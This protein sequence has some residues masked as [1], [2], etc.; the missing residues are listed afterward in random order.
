MIT[1]IICS[2]VVGLLIGVIT[3]AMIESNNPFNSC[4][5]HWDYN[6]KSGKV[7]GLEMRIFQLERENERLNSIFNS[8][9][10][11]KRLFHERYAAHCYSC[12]KN[13]Y[14]STPKGQEVADMLKNITLT[15]E[16]IAEKLGI[17]IE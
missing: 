6:I 3:G 1:A 11:N 14:S 5:L 15:S 8:Y 17:K 13:F 16:E 12:N 10:M 2:V 9:E 7:A 4:P